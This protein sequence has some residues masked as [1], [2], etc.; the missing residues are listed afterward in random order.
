[1]KK[2]IAT[3]FYHDSQDLG[4]SYGNIFL[5]LNKRNI[6]YWQT[7][8]TLFFSS[9][10]FNKDTDVNYLLFT[11]VS[12]F[13][14]RNE[15]EALGVKVYDDLT[16]TSRGSDRW[17][18][19]R[20]FF[21]VIDF[22]YKN[23]DF[24]NEDSIVMLDTDVVAMRDASTLFYYLNTANNAIGY[25]FERSTDKKPVFHGL[26]I[27]ELK[28]IGFDLFGNSSEIVNLIGGEFF[29]FKK[30]QISEF[31]SYFHAVNISKYNSKLT[32]EEQI[33]T[34]VNAQI[35]W[36][37]FP[38]AICRVWT[39]LRVFSIPNDPSNYIF[40]HL[41]SEKELGL[42]KLFSA[43]QNIDP[44]L[45]NVQNFH[46]LFYRCIPLKHPFILYINKLKIRIFNLFKGNQS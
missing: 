23:N 3:Y 35:S 45:M 5:P 2:Y 15:I 6:I 28:E 32:T 25:I 13:P 9:I 1:M 14:F 40:L 44:H 20:F 31:L 16:L 21:D 43:T 41:P 46:Q 12:N 22:V 33:L 11:N 17:A 4:A 38:D 30:S 37:V 34:L 42:N 27:S 19:V 26:H 7:V 36:S 10:V 24:S 39:T 29:A 8:Y 18:T